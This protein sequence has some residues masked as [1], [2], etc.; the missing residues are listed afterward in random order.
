MADSHHDGSD[1]PP[2]KYTPTDFELYIQNTVP[3]NKERASSDEEHSA[4]TDNKFAVCLHRWIA[5]QGLKYATV[6]GKLKG[7]KWENIKHFSGKWH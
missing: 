3:G 7:L 4:E 1:E 6:A 2:V 5:Y